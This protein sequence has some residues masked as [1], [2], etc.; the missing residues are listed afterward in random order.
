MTKFKKDVTNVIVVTEADDD[1]WDDVVKMYANSM[2]VFEKQKGFL[3]GTV[4][5]SQD[6]KKLIGVLQWESKEDHLACLTSP[7]W[8][9]LTDADK[10]FQLM[11]SGKIRMQPEV[12]G[13][14][15]EAKV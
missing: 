6:S 7:D 8:Q 4:L 2:S 3:G 5:K 14:I 1:V 13:V 12:Y 11:E 15:S 9:Q 10:W